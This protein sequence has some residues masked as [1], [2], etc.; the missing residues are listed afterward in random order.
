MLK[1]ALRLV[2]IICWLAINLCD[3]ILDIQPLALRICNPSGIFMPIPAI[4]T[5]DLNF[6]GTPGTI[7]VYLIPH[8]NGAILIESGP[9]STTQTLEVA[10]HAHGMQTNDITDVFLTHIHLDHAGAA[11][12]LA[13]QGA[14]VHVHPIGAPHMQNPERLL[15][16]ARRIYG[17]S[18]D[19]LW[20]DFLPVPGDRLSVLQDGDTIEIN[21]IC[22]RAIE[23]PGHASHH[24]AYIYED[25]CFSGDIG[26]VRLGGLRH[27]SLP[28]PPP[29]FHLE[30]WRESVRRLHKE[31]INYIAPTH[32]GIYQDVEWHLAAIDKALDE[33]DEWIEVV[34][35]TEPS[36]E[37]LRVKILDWERTRAIW[38]GVDS[39]TANA[40][41]VA[42][43][44]SMSADGIQRYWLKH[45]NNS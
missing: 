45:R 18:M 39:S 22:I 11:G 27:I 6:R 37:E 33:V 32:F 29:E 4:K 9:G 35:P 10:L 21:G 28:M 43:P 8:S 42:N 13:Q 20:G 14:Q 34:M 17:D 31:P 38:G 1:L 19:T 5:L 30:K 25:V 23:S 36:I 40:Q 44:S 3:K 12:W 2:A 24:L 41:Q 26:G 16:S 7:A 15:A